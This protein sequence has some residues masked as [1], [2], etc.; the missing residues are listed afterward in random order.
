VRSV[1]EVEG[2]AG[3]VAVA[4]KGHATIAADLVRAGTDLTAVDSQQW[5][6]LMYAAWRG[7]A[8]TVPAFLESRKIKTVSER[9]RK[10]ARTLAARQ[11]GIVR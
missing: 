4:W 2:E 8:G 1:D 11:R 9:E 6:A 10:H 5:A 3:D 7:H